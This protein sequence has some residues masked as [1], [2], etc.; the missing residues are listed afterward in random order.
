ME[1]LLKI[2]PFLLFFI[3]TARPLSAEDR[4]IG[5][6]SLT[7]K[8]LLNINSRDI[9]SFRAFMDFD[10]TQ[11]NFEAYS[12]KGFDRKILGFWK[13]LL[14]RTFTND[15]K[16]GSLLRIDNGLTGKANDTINLTG[17]FSW[18][19]GRYNFIGSI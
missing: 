5:K 4:S 17:I 10:F 13:S 1:K 7:G 12:R 3:F 8:W 16:N 2:I 15:F 14:A 18:A 19:I 9:G 11:G 6:D